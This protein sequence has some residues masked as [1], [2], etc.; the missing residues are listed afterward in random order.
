MRKLDIKFNLFNPDSCEFPTA[1]MEIL[2]TECYH[3]GAKT[4]HSVD[5]DLIDYKKVAEDYKEA[6]ESIMKEVDRMI[7]DINVMHPENPVLDYINNRRETMIDE[8]KKLFE[9]RR[10]LEDEE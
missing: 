10:G 5:A 4:R 7:K 9:N 8:L 6:G 3:C 2:E 1:G